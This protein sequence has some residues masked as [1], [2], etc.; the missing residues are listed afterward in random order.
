MTILANG[1][2]GGLE[3]TVSHLK[4]RGGGAFQR[5]SYNNRE[6]TVSFT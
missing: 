2:G 1:N 3:F 5:E 4:G 6:N